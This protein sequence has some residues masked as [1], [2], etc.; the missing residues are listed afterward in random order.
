MDGV[1]LNHTNDHVRCQQNANMEAKFSTSFRVARNSGYTVLF[2]GL[3]GSDRVLP[4]IA[5][6]ISCNSYVNIMDQYHPSWH[7]QGGSNLSLPSLLQRKITLEEYLFAIK[8][9]LNSGL[10]RDF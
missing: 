10:H 2:Y 5:K 9:A 8:C 7:T 4:W 3:T 1:K 6:E